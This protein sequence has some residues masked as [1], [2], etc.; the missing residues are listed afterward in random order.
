ML[1]VLVNLS[2]STALHR[3]LPAETTT[4]RGERRTQAASERPEAS[5]QRLF[6]TA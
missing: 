4:R 5:S 3:P 6:E 2:D 1:V